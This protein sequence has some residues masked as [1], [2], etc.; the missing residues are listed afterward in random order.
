MDVITLEEFRK[1]IAI[2]FSKK[3]VKPLAP[4]GEKEQVLYQQWLKGKEKLRTLT[5][6]E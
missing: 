3:G 2:E 1:I 5:K 6:N 4:G